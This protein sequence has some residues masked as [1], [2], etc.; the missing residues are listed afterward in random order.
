MI[1]VKPDKNRVYIQCS[2]TERKVVAEKLQRQQYEKKSAWHTKKVRQIYPFPKL[3]WFYRNRCALAVDTL[4]VPYYRLIS[5]VVS[6]ELAAW[7]SAEE[8]I[9]KM[10]I[11]QLER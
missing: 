3:I 6:T 2:E 1:K 4:D 10:L 11:E 7:A 8:E 5:R 9:D